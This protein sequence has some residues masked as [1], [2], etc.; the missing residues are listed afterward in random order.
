[1]KNIFLFILI[2]VFLTTEL[3]SQS[4]YVGTT[5]GFVDHLEKDCG[6]VYS[7][8]GIPTDPFVSVANHGAN[9]VRFAVSLPPYSS[10]YTQGEIVDYASVEKVKTGLQRAKDAGLKTLI[11]FTYQSFALED[12][13]KLNEYVSPLA[14]QSIAADLRKI[15]DSVYQHTFSTLDYYCSLGL[16]PEIVAVGNESTWRRLEPNLP[17]SL[18]P[19]YDPARSVAIH[20]AGS[21]AVRDISAKYK[22]NIKVCFHLMGPERTEWWL[23]EHSPYN[24][25]VDMIG[26]SLYH[27]WNNNNYGSYTSLGKFVAGITSAY[28]VEFI[29][30]ETAQL[31]TTGGNDKHVD[32]LGTENIPVSYP[33]PP[34]TQTQKQYLINLTN[35]VIKN[36]GSGVIV[37]GAEWVAHNCYI[38]PDKYG[39]G[40]SW[41]NKAFWDFTYNLHDG[42]NWMLP[43]TSDTTTFFTLTTKVIGKGNVVPV[44]GMYQ[45][46]E[47]VNLMAKP[48]LGWQFVKWSGDTS[49]TSNPLSININ[50]NKTITATFI[51][52]PK[53]AVTFKVKMTGVN[54][55]NGVYVTGD[56]PNNSGEPWKLNKM[57][58]YEGNDTF[59]YTTLVDAESFGA[60]Y[61][62]NQ[63]SWNARETV[64]QACAKVWNVDRQYVTQQNDTV[65]D[66]IWGSCQRI[67]SQTTSVSHSEMTDLLIYPNPLI[68]NEIFIQHGYIQDLTFMLYDIVGRKVFCTFVSIN[69]S[70]LTSLQLPEN[71]QNGIYFAEFL[72][73]QNRI[74]KKILISFQ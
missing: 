64:P 66:F 30:M 42:I 7:E 71:I 36:G 49:S 56:F 58:I 37:W 59:S 20:N 74:V 5:M 61:F 35:E 32:I 62:L 46:N 15:T 27:G 18:L 4:I 23:K 21:K 70:R 11:T 2:V 67:N 31:F 65:F 24:L 39:K 48:S 1:M 13:Q 9:I 52:K 19:A 45:S 51:E 33:N 6:I 34:T 22:V 69:N 29:V 60:Y 72:T 47:K 38:Y 63:N 12:S 25:D 55:S 14:W 3:K 44:G 16:I 43:F 10:S 68:T 41:E 26:I 57:V 40:S 73:D 17:E 28:Q 54:V 53:V 50:S 8:N